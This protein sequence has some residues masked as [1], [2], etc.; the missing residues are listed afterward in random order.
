MWGDSHLPQLAI[1]PQVDLVIS[2]GGHNTFTE[3]FALG[4]PMLVLPVAFDQH[5]NGQR[6]HET[7]FGLRLDPFHCT[8]RELTQAVDTLLA[9]EALRRRLSAAAQ[10]IAA[11][12]A[13]EQVAIKLE[14]M[15]GAK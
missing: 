4:K 11:S 1:V 5:N 10:R 15:L 14:Q 13:H 9:D 7:G 6:L 2:H 3:C 12:N 8:E